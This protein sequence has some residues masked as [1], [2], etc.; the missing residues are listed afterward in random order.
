MIQ[1]DTEGQAQLL[2]LLAFYNTTL[3]EER[4][5]YQ[6]KNCRQNFLIT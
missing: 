4:E 3:W 2:E 5:K 6:K 1:Y